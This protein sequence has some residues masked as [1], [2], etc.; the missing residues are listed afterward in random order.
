ML[1]FIIQGRY[2]HEAMRGMAA[3]PEGRAEAAE[4][5]MEEA[6]GRLAAFYLTFGPYDFLCVC[7]APNEDTM[8]A[9]QAAVRAGG[10]GKVVR[11]TFTALGTDLRV[12]LVLTQELYLTLLG[13]PQGQTVEQVCREACRAA[14]AHATG[15]SVPP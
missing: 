8:A 13:N 14:L 15:R 10:S 1:T 11:A 6:G 9:V 3:S 2:S 12:E 5:M 7:E 4:K